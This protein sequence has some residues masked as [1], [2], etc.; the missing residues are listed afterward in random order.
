[1]FVGGLRTEKVG[2]AAALKKQ[3]VRLAHLESCVEQLT[4]QVMILA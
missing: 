2:N 4:K 1:M 3:E